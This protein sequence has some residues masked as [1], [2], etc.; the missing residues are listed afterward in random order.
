MNVSNSTPIKLT[1]LSR[2]T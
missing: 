2:I 1:L